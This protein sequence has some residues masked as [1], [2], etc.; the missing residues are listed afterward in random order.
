MVLL[1]KKEALDQSQRKRRKEEERR[2]YLSV[3]E[4]AEG[5]ENLIRRVRVGGTT[6]H[7]VDEAI[8]ADLVRAITEFSDELVELSIRGVLTKTLE[9]GLELEATERARFVLVKV[10]KDLLELIDLLGRSL[11]V[12][13]EEDLLLDEFLLGLLAGDEL[14]ELGLQALVVEVG[15]LSRGR[16]LELHHGG[17]E[18][19]DGVESG[20]SGREVVD[21]SLDGVELVLKLTTGLS[22]QLSLLCEPSREFGGLLS[23][24][25]SDLVVA[26]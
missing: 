24:L 13:L 9:T 2:K 19:S 23:K 14:L 6:D 7:K 22:E 16:D 5:S 25:A 11:G 17:S 12:L 18:A 1:E 8:K 26:C 3:G 10:G 4:F 15:V 21:A 20:L